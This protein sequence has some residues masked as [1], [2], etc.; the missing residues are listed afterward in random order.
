MALTREFKETVKA[1]ARRD[2]E[3]REA[4]LV[5]A[6]EQLKAGD[7]EVGQVILCDYLSAT[8]T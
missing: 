4:L 5:E 1:R 8:E 2:D 3:F 6:I 7:F